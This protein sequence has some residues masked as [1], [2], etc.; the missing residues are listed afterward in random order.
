VSALDLAAFDAMG[1]NL[2]ADAL[3]RN[4][5]YKRSTAQIYSAAVPEP[6]SW[7]LMIGGFGAIGA[8]LRL[9]RTAVSFG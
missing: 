5:A 4:G 3:A 7:A 6:A 8:S 2:A 9:R 1:W